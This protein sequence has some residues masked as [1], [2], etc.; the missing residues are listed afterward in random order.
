MINTI[1]FTGIAAIIFYFTVYAFF[2]WL[3]ENSYSFLTTRKFLKDGFFWGPFKPMYGFAPIMLV[4]F[5][6]P[7]TY[8]LVVL[9][10]CLIIPT[11]IEYVSGFL[12]QT[13][14]HRKWW[15]YSDIP[16][17]L[18]GHICLSFSICWIF[19]A[20]I[21]LKWVHPVVHS[22]YSQ[23]DSVWIWLSPIIALYFLAELIL[24]FRRHSPAHASYGKQSNL[25][26]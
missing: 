22:I 26:E 21:C 11:L 9:F 16:M 24:S 2:G 14:F 10:L 17:Q 15:D 12:L 20:F 4:Y 18:H 23:I 19:L 13:F 5:I 8:W 1:E 6:S 25:L 3:I 7:N